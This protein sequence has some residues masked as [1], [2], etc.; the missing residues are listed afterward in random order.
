MVIFPKTDN[1]KTENQNDDFWIFGF[2]IRCQIVTYKDS[3]GFEMTSDGSGCLLIL[4]FFEKPCSIGRLGVLDFLT[5]PVHL[6]I[7]CCRVLSEDGANS[8]VV[9]MESQ[10]TV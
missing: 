6:G 9:Q 10:E 1:P 4:Y 2:I 5:E 3:S 7:Q 8:A